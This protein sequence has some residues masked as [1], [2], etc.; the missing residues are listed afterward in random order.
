MK[1]FIFVCFAIILFNPLIGDE[2]TLEWEASVNYGVRGQ[3][4]V[5]VNDTLLCHVGGKTYYGTPFGA[6]YDYSF[7]E[8]FTQSNGYWD[9]KETTTIQREYINAHGYDSKIYI[10][11]GAGYPVYPNEV[12]IYDP[13]AETITYGTPF[14]SPRAQAAS[15]IYDGKIYIFGGTNG[16]EYLNSLW[17]YDIDTASWSQGSYFPIPMSVIDAV[18]HNGKIYSIGGFDGTTHDEV[19]AYDIALDSWTLV[20]NS[21]IPVSTN[22]LAVYQDYIYSIGAYNDE[23]LIMRYD[24]SNGSWITYDSNFLGRR[25][26]STVN[27][28]NKILIVAG[29]ARYN[30]NY[31]YF[32][33]VQSIDP[34]IITGVDDIIPDTSVLKQELELNQNSPNPFNPSTTINYTINKTGVI[35]INIYNITGQLVRTLVNEHRDIGD[36]EIIWNGKNNDGIDVSSGQYF[37]QIKSDEFVSSKKMI[38]LK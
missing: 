35:E 37:Y 4:T 10:L 18:Y 6:T 17:I 5:V 28:D 11:G 26:A 22:C 14:P 25:H 32:R 8:T 21:P 15:A 16:N 34:S 38:L 2:I 24:I 12:E 29:V 19:F 30:D 7:I 33:I 31:Q 36:Y 9:I 3:R 20:D 1:T 13:Y 27:Y 23:D